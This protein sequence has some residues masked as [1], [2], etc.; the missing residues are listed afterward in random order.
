MVEPMWGAILAGGG[1]GRG[2]TEPFFF[3]SSEETGKECE[4]GGTRRQGGRVRGGA[5]EGAGEGSGGW[6]Q[7]GEGGGLEVGGCAGRG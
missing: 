5:D 7:G 3:S 4:S 2:L 1:Q 6:G